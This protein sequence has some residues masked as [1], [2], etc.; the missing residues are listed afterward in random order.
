[1][2]RNTEIARTLYDA[3]NSRNFERSMALADPDVKWLNLSTGQTFEGKEG[4][5][6]YMTGWATAFPDSKVNILNMTADEDTIVTEFAGRGT[7]DG[8][9]AT[10]A[11]DIPP[12]G[13]PI[14]VPFCEVLRVKD[15]KIVEGRIYFDSATML[16]QLG[17][18]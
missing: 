14:D 17:V 15:G 13:R 8:V 6:A 3:Y 12:T 7:H 2:N 18:A 5:L 9:L 1:M 4:L 16:R 11:G 10:P